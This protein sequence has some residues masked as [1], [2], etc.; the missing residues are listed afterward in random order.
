MPFMIG[1]H[2]VLADAEVQGPAVR[3]RA[4]E[5]VADR[6][7]AVGAVHGGVVAAGQVGRAAPELGQHVG[8]RAQHLRRWR[9]GSPAP[10]RPPRTSGGAAPSRPRA[11]G[12]AAGR[13]APGPAGGP[14][15]RRRSAAATRRAPGGRGRRP[16]GRAR[17][18]RPGPRSAVSGS[19]PSASLVSRD[20]V[21]AERRAVRLA[22]VLQVRRREADDRAHRDERRALGLLLR[23]AQGGVQRVHVLAV[24]DPLDVPAVGLVAGRHVLAERGVGVALDGDVVVVV[25]DDQAA[26]LLVAGQRAGLAGDTLL[27]RRRRSRRTRSC[28]R[29]GSARAR[30]RGPAGRARG[31]PPWP[32]RR[33]SRRP[34]RAGRW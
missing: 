15:P 32:C 14:A 34:G 25:E 24:V 7:E 13:A 5:R 23:R 11:C 17:A 10:W 1:P 4:L 29:T 12:C 21:G 2:R 16:A 8:E 19:K 20:L 22:G 28:G 18:R 9:T 6:Q 33:R 31:G 3:V 26:E 30:R 27:R